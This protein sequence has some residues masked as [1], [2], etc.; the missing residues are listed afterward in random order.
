MSMRE[1]LSIEN[2]CCCTV[3]GC[4][5]VVGWSQ[6][7]RCRLSSS[8]V[9]VVCNCN[10]LRPSGESGGDPDLPPVGDGEESTI[11]RKVSQKLCVPLGA[12]SFERHDG[13][14]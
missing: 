10:V 11:R 3:V 4:G 5:V 1:D 2:E 8:R 9:N 6:I 7:A 13:I 14:A 12:S